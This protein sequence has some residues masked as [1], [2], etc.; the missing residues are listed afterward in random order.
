MGHAGGLQDPRPGEPEDVGEYGLSVRAREDPRSELASREKAVDLL[1]VAVL[2]QGLG[3]LM[4][5]VDPTL[6]VALRRVITFV[7]RA[8][9][10]LRKRLLSSLWLAE[11]ALALDPAL[12]HR[13]PGR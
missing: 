4:G 12:Q 3:Q 5:D 10:V 2:R 1:L 8:P 11:R 13:G 6:A 9:H 7:F